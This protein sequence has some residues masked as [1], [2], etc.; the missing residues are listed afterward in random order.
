MKIENIL[1]HS[2]MS[3]PLHEASLILD[4]GANE[5][6][7]ARWM[8]E[9]TPAQVHSFEPDPRLFAVLPVLPRV[10]WHPLAVDGESGEFDLAL[11]EAT[12]SSA[13]YRERTGQVTVRVK[14]TSLDDFCR[15]HGITRIDL[16]KIDIEGAE[17]SL[18]E[19]TSDALLRSTA[20]ITVEFHDFF[21]RE[22][23]P[24][25]AGIFRRLEG[26]GFYGVRFSHFY[27][28]DCLFVNQRIAPLSALDKLS[29]QVAGK[30]VP[31]IGR[32]T[33]RH[34]RKLVGR[35]GAGLPQR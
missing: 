27:W 15:T 9:H 12:C 34:W 6:G 17:L 11:G 22:D 20:Q 24:R 13:L 1:N 28:S 26:L 33:R 31:G 8:C 25:I 19:K 2:F 35:G 29:I 3:A 18:L 4:C 21:R 5:G 7:F 16:V 14:K 30:F 23:L 10:I 32:F